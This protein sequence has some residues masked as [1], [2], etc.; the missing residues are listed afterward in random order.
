MEN[1]QINR[2][3]SCFQNSIWNRKIHF[4]VPSTAFYTKVKNLSEWVYLSRFAKFR[5]HEFSFFKCRFTYSSYFQPELSF[6]LIAKLINIEK[7]LLGMNTTTSM[8]YVMIMNKPIEVR[9]IHNWYFGGYKAKIYTAKRKFHFQHF[10]PTVQQ[11]RN[12]GT[13][14]IFTVETIFFCQM[15]F[16]K[17]GRLQL[18]SFEMNP[19]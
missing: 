17:V 8:I 11:I 10:N 1:S 2:F 14:I 9:F 6:G 4:F 5:Q 19:L 3:F 12:S 16:S 18:A 13:R 7:C 15:A